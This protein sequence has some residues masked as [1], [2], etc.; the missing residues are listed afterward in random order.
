PFLK[1]FYDHCCTMRHYSFTIKKCG[2]DNCSICR[3]P[4]CLR[5]IFDQLFPLPDP[6]PGNDLHYKSFEELYGSET[7][8]KYRPSSHGTKS[9]SVKHKHQQKHTMPFCP[10]ALRAKNVGITVTCVECDKSRLLFSARKL[11]DKDRQILLQ[12]LDMILYSC[13]TSFKN[14]N[15]LASTTPSASLEIAVETNEQD[16]NNNYEEPGND[17]EL[18]END[19]YQSD[20][21]DDNYNIESRDSEA[22]SIEDTTSDPIQELFNRVFVNDLLTC[23][24]PI[25]KPYYSAK[26]Y[27][28]ICYLCGSSK[29]PN[30]VTSKGLWPTCHECV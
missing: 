19:D 11:L 7:T 30:V 1:K 9:N 27:P 25:E 23:S 20:Q 29:I 16:S 14:I 18:D 4:R 2:K 8:E 5:E 28:N 24:T 6:V 15:E 13:G 22:N 3:P 21:D 10:S 17:I 12:F 26:I